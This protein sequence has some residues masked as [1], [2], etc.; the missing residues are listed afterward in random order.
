MQDKHIE[1]STYI[2]IEQC[3]L[4]KYVTVMY[5]KNL[6]TSKYNNKLGLYCVLHI[7]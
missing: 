2:F 7:S 5:F 4:E 3:V 1:N 6:S